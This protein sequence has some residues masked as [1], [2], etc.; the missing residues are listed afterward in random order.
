M[1][2]ILCGLANAA[3][4]FTVTTETGMNPIWSLVLT[5]VG[6]I[7]YAVINIG[8][9]VLTSYLQKKGVISDN[10]KKEI[11]EVADDLA[12]DG[13]INNSTKKED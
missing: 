11:D 3:T 1:S 2:D 6:S 5:L 9:K 8:I 12:D 7:V 4:I 10:T 13:K